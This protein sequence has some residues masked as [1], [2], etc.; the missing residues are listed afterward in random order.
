MSATPAVGPAVM[1]AEPPL[2]PAVDELPPDPGR[3]AYVGDGPHRSVA[4]IGP[5]GAL[6]PLLPPGAAGNDC[7]ASARGDDM[8]WVSDRSGTGEGVFRRTGDGP[9]TPVV[10]LDGGRLADPVLSPDRRWIA[11]VSWENDDGEGSR[12]SAYRCDDSRG[13]FGGAQPSVWVVR[14]DGTG[15]REAVSNADWAD[16]S[17]DGTEFVFTR[18]QRAYRTTVAAGGAQVPVSYG[19]TP[20]AKP[21]WEPAAPGGRDRIA[22][23]T[24]TGRGEQALATV[25]AA[26]RGETP[27]DILA[28]GDRYQDARHGAAWK[29]DGKEL[30]F[31]SREPYLV[32]ARAEA[33]GTCRGTPLYDP[34]EVVGYE[35]ESVGWHT[36]AG[37]EPVVMVSGKD[38]ED[39]TIESQRAA[40]P[41]DRLE[42]RAGQGE[43]SAL[44]DPAYAPDGRRMA[45]V[46]TTGPPDAPDTERILVGE[47]LGLA[48]AVPL[49]YKG[50]GVNEFQERP[51]WSP[52]GTKL[53]FARSAPPTRG[54]PDPAAQIV[55]VDISRGPQDGQLLHEVPERTRPGYGCYSDDRDPS[56]SP[57]GGKLAFSRRS[58]CSRIN[59]VPGQPLRGPAPGGPR[60]AVDDDS[61][62]GTSDGSGPPADGSEPPSDDGAGTSDGPVRPQGDTRDRHIWTAG[63]TPGGGVPFD[64][65]AAQC[66]SPECRVVDVRPAY[67]P[68][69]SSIAFVRQTTVP[70]GPGLRAAPV[71][72]YEG[73]RMVLEV[74]DDGTRCRGL[75]PFGDACPLAV[76]APDGDGPGY[77]MPDNPAWSPDGHRLAVDVVVSGWDSVTDRRIRVVDPANGQ[78]ETLPGKLYNGQQQP[79]WKP[80]S[81]LRVHL[82][83]AD[84]PLMLGDTGTVVLVVRNHGVADAPRTGVR[85]E[86]P[87]GL[88]FVAPSDPEGACAADPA[89]AGQLLCDVGV[90]KS[91]TEARIELD[92]KGV[93]PGAQTIEA[94]AGGALTD[95]QP[96]DNTDE[97]VVQVVVPDLAVTATATPPVIKIR[98]RSTVEFTV[99]NAGSATALNT[100][101]TPAVPPGLTLMSGTQCPA[102]G[103]DLGSIAPGAEKKVTLVYTAR[104]AF[105]GTIEGRVTAT[106]R[107]NNPDNDRASVDLTVVDP[108][109]PDPAVTVTAAP[110]RIPTGDRSTVVYT[111]RNLGDAPAKSVLL[112]PVLPSGLTVV[113]ATPA[114]PATGCAL[115]DLAPGATVTVTRVVTASSALRGSVA[116]TVTTPG[117]D[118]DPGNNSASAP[119]TV[120][121]RPSPPRRSAD[122]SVSVTAGPR[123]AYSGGRITAEA[124]IRN[125]GQVTATGLTLKVVVPPGLRVVSVSRPPCLTADGCGLGNLAPAA[126]TTVRLRLAA[127]RALTGAITATVTTTGSDSNLANNTA[128]APLTVRRPV[129][130]LDPELGP[131][132]AVT[133]ARGSSFPPGATVRL[134]WSEGVTAASAPVVVGADGTFSAPVLVLVQDALGPRE[135]RATHDAVPVPLFR[136]VKAEYL[137]VPGVLQPSVFQWRR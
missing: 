91:G 75:V 99:R 56:W 106:T 80:S 39:F 111:V 104:N 115:G 130:R 74:G 125:G 89:D 69:T 7:Q 13:R 107:D 66:G 127:D 117:P 62:G 34:Y 113:T 59:A 12:T 90:L 32:D 17:P 44:S 41:L 100:R 38:P 126:R 70:T 45:F 22:Y 122:P 53:A 109:M 110:S 31:L 48:R 4:T 77:D 5:G 16:W 42:L 86:L 21:V 63:A 30:V 33:C 73:P 123:T 29:P 46:R 134:R 128:S 19:Q 108:R 15:L 65:S 58:D 36:P 9:V 95:H 43:E 87:T 1:A 61:G 40:V 25:P 64:V 94:T 85:V 55:V 57:D 52:D 131:P 102:T 54:N 35:T 51:A 10:H 88:D 24:R 105:S 82:T 49:R 98:E 23:I 18:D 124:T 47:E 101:L 2:A 121:E 81:D 11:F 67:R 71:S 76:P 84:S 79:T 135:L 8:V 14:T 118:T 120:D 68:G 20:A 78:G 3:I 26:G 72:G 60:I 133:Q 129:L 37:G 28:V 136:E 97:L 112:T 103:C 27:A 116:G 83:T 92:V 96:Q 137:V 6:V 132:G 93:A 114:C 50:M 119:L